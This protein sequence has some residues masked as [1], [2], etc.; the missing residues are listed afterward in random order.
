[1]NGLIAFILFAVFIVIVFRQEIIMKN[2]IYTHITQP[3]NYKEIKIVERTQNIYIN[4]IG[5]SNSMCKEFVVSCVLCIILTSIFLFV[6]KQEIIMEKTIKIKEVENISIQD[7]VGSLIMH[8]IKNGS[9][10]F[11]GGDRYTL[12][13]S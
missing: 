11:Q 12:G 5:H 4:H 7:A 10:Q 8:L 3:D 2:V 1:M 13:Q 9:T 6:F